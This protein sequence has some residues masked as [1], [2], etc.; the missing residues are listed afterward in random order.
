MK[1]QI[2]KS[3]NRFHRGS[4]RGG[5]GRSLSGHGEGGSQQGR[6]EKGTARVRKN[7]LGKASVL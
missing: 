4:Y 5:G 3:K 1:I 2:V 6:E 7:N